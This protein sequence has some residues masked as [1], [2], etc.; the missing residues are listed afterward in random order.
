MKLILIHHWIQQIHTEK[1]LA[2]NFT[3]TKENPI[4]K[5]KEEEKKGAARKICSRL[6]AR[7]SDSCS[8]ARTLVTPVDRAQWY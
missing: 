6:A 3:R 4:K 5:L 7:G 2:R 8:Q 1:L